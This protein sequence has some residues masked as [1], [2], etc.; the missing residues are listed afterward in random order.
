MGS[1]QGE[2]WGLTHRDFRVSNCVVGGDRYKP[3]DFDGGGE[4]PSP[5][6]LARLLDHGLD[7]SR[8][9][10]IGRTFLHVAA[11]ITLGHR[12]RLGGAQRLRAASTAAGLMRR[13]PSQLR[14][15]RPT[16]QSRD[17]SLA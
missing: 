2:P 14:T 9:N 3:I 12:P 5:E 17:R 13:G 11:A 15:L 8:P 4:L 1:W 16:T 10:W 6:L 7:V